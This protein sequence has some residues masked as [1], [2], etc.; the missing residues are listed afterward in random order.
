MLNYKKLFT[1]ILNKLNNFQFNDLKDGFTYKYFPISNGSTATFTIN[2]DSMYALITITCPASGARGMYI[3]YGRDTQ[4]SLGVT[5]VASGS[6]VPTYVST[7]KFSIS[8]S[9][10]YSS[11]A[12]CMIFTGNITRDT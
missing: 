2:S 8:N 12:R 6:I 4:S 3:I 7:G 9:S 5:T 11:Q 10:G 1:K